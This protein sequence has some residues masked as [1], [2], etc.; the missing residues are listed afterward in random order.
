MLREF[1]IENKVLSITTDSAPNMVN[2]IDYL[3]KM[4]EMKDVLHVRCAAHVINLGVSVMLEKLEDSQIKKIRS[5]AKKV[6][7]NYV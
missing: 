4:G 3:R 2:S 6:S 5:I 7:F 1:N